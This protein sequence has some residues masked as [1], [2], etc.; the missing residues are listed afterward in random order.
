VA[1]EIAEVA[2]PDGQ[3]I[4]ARVTA[5]PEARDI[6]FRKGG[7]LL[8]E[9]LSR[10][11][12]AVVDNLHE[13]VHRHRPDEVSVEFGIELSA[14]SGKVVSVLAE[15]GATSSITVQLTWRRPEPV[16]ST[17]GPARPP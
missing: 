1:T 10:T 7:Q 17:A 11:V 15:A 14:R 13:A 3:V 16:E 6:A 5:G 4:L 9:G 12:H 8:L 2:L